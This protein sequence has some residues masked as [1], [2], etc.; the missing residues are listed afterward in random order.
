MLEVEMFPSYERW[1]EKLRDRTARS[2]ILARIFQI[3]THGEYMGDFKSVGDGVIELRVHVGPGY[4]IYTTLR[5]GRLL[6][7]MC[8]GTKRRQQADVERAK[9]LLKEWDKEHGH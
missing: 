5:D 6:L 3:K 4:R 7:L 8:G 1:F 2:L 9:E